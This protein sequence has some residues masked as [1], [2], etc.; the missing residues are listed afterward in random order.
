M[1]SGLIRI[2]W[3]GV[4]FCF[5]SLFL[6]KDG[7]CTSQIG[8]LGFINWW[9]LLAVIYWR[10]I[11]TKK[12]QKTT[13]KFWQ[14]KWKCLKQYNQ[15]GDGKGLWVN[16]MLFFR[17]MWVLGSLKFR[18]KFWKST[19]TWLLY[20]QGYA[21]CMHFVDTLE[22]IEEKQHLFNCWSSIRGEFGRKRKGKNH[23][24]PHRFQ[25]HLA[26]SP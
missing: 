7:R 1:H 21:G 15:A 18:T 16:S 19:E 4:L 20:A 2:V 17:Q 11:K 10:S 22:K 3:T 5:I 6:R 13:E 25:N 9:D 23:R 8:I 12:T 24:L 26:N 14:T